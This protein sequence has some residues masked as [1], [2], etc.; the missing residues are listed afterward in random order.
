MNGFSLRQRKSPVKENT[1]NGYH[2]SGLAH[3]N[4]QHKVKVT[5]KSEHIIYFL[6]YK[7]VLVLTDW[8]K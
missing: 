2:L 8:E 5:R 7:L 6:S 1:S 4:L 3:A